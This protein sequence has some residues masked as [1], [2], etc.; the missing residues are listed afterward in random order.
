L[1][2]DPKANGQRRRGKGRREERVSSDEGELEEGCKVDEIGTYV[3]SD[4]LQPLIL[5]FVLGSAH[6]GLYS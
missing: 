6:L 4:V 2:I 5:V 1:L 3:G